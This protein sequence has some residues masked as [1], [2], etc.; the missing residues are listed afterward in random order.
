MSTRGYGATK[1]DGTLWTWGQYN[2]SGDFGQNHTNSRSSP[3]QVPGTTWDLENMRSHASATSN[4]GGF[5]K[6]TT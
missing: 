1:T 6:Q 5:I 2:T 4:L 3:V